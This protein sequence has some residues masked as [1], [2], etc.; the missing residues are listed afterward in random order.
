LNPLRNIG[1]QAAPGG[2]DP[3]LRDSA[4]ACL[5][6]SSQRRLLKSRGRTVT[7]TS[8]VHLAKSRERLQ[9]EDLG[10]GVFN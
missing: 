5:F 3:Y 2:A 10:Q 6:E 8:H 1:Q 7:F 9:C 4:A